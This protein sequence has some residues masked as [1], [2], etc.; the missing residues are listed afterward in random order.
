MATPLR[1]G[2]ALIFVLSFA[3]FSCAV[4]FVGGGREAPETLRIAQQIEQLLQDT[5]FISTQ[6]AIKVVS[7][8]NGE[9]LYKRNSSLLFHPA[10]NQK[11]LTSAAALTMLGD[12]F[13][14]KTLLSTDGVLEDTA[15][16][17]NIYVK[18]YGD[19][20][21]DSVDLAAIAGQLS[22][23]GIR[24]V[25]GNLV[26]DVS[27]FDDRFWGNGWMWDDEPEPEEMF[28]TPLSVHHNAITVSVS[29]GTRGDDPVLVR[30][31]PATGYV[32]ILNEGQTVQDTVTAELEVTRLWEERTNVIHVTGQMLQSAATREYTL[33]VWR[34]EFYALTLL[35]EEMERQGV[36][37][38]GELIVGSTPENVQE[39]F[40]I[41]RSIDSVV[42]YLN[43][44]S[45]NL[46]AENLLKT[47]GAEFRGA[48]GTAQNGIFVVNEFLA[49]LGLDT[50]RAFLADG[51]G[52]SR[53]NLVNAE[54]IIQLL[55][56][57]TSEE[58]LF[59]RFSVSLPIAGVD[60]TLED[61]MVGSRAQG[62]AHAK[63]G[64]LAGVSNL[65][66]YVTTR[67]GELLAF[68]ILMQNFLGSAIPYRD[69]QDRIITMLADY[70]REDLALSP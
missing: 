27:Y 52:V 57:M 43:K 58:T 45:D 1:T 54:T 25:N 48:P 28:I 36:R 62:N 18:G 14:F 38:S 24:L 8:D 31:Q 13:A 29:P 61:R 50:T 21:L 63:T 19:P 47:L 26:G 6:V 33:S 12:E 16:A 4:P 23:Q 39:I 56:A 46:S 51:S 22:S 35:K 17:G 67:D 64:T 11:L 66:G 10:S 30:T 65:S 59:E 2:P 9:I 55:T 7:V 68:S 5:L 34:P 20:L 41:E 37:V 3:F 44:E 70:S 42:V 15:L 53:Y 40:Q 60:G 49:S 32:T 69:V